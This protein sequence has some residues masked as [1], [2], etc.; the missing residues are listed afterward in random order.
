M[1]VCH[2]DVNPDEMQ[3]Y[4]NSDEM[5]HHTAFYSSLNSLANFMS[6]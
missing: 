4:G 2:E 5:L 6:L 1:P 3:Y